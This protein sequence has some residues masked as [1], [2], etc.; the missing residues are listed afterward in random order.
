VVVYYYYY[1]Y[2]WVENGEVGAHVDGDSL[3]I[4]HDTKMMLTNFGN[5]LQFGH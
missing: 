4:L 2:M 3:G 5:V 1:T